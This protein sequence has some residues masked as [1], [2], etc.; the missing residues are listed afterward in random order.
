M[1]ITPLDQAFQFTTTIQPAQVI[2]QYITTCI[3]CSNSQPSRP[4]SQDGTF[5]QCLTCNKQ[6]KAQVTISNKQRQ[7]Q[8]PSQNMSQ[9]VIFKKPTFETMRPIYFPQKENK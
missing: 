1:N 5:R 9:N 6:F 4:L 7:D 3:F 2:P 8:S